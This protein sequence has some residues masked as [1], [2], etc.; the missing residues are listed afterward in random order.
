MTNYLIKYGLSNFFT[1]SLKIED[2]ENIG[3]IICT[4][5]KGFRVINNVGLELNAIIKGSFIHYKSSKS[6]ELPKL[7]DFVILEH[8]NQDNT[9]IKY[10]LP[11]K[12]ELKRKL[13]GEKKEDQIIATNIDFAFVTNPI[14]EQ[15][16]IRKIERLILACRD[17]NIIPIIVVTKADLSK[18]INLE[19]QELFET[20][21]DI[22]II[23]TSL[24]NQDSTKEI[25][26]MLKNNKIGTF[27]G[28]S[29]S[30][31]STLTNILMKSAVQ[32][33]L[34]VSGDKDKGRHTTT[35]R[36]MFLLESG[37]CI[38][39]N[40]GIKEFA[41]W[42]DNDDSIDKTFN[43]I[44]ELAQQ[45]KFSDCTHTKEPDC[46]VLQAIVEGS[47]SQDRLN[48]Y[49]KLKFEEGNINLIKKKYEK[50]ESTKAINKYYSQAIKFKKSKYID[51]TY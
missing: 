37:G 13:A 51:D 43:D 42:L 38:I 19:T 39:D 16:N 8:M 26:E 3:K 31:K 17:S 50:K 12:N 45:C 9:Y 24:D 48:N 47:L 46:A 35:H 34:S 33:T 27:I 41:L 14:G 30:G 20:F 11:R 29:G 10:I 49:L 6:A 23:I 5:K 25:L 44:A 21:S 4:H 7:G 36:E 22:K 15:F 40:P 32:K 1:S 18:N 28:S 2:L